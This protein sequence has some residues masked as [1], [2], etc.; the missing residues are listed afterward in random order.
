MK[1]F[2]DKTKMISLKDAYLHSYGVEK[3]RMKRLYDSLGD[4]L[5][6]KEF[7]DGFLA[8]YSYRDSRREDLPL[9]TDSLKTLYG[10]SLAY[11]ELTSTSIKMIM[12]E[13][14][15]D[16]FDTLQPLQVFD[17]KSLEEKEKA[18]PEF[19]EFIC[20]AADQSD[21]EFQKEAEKAL[22]L[23]PMYGEEFA[24]YISKLILLYHKKFDDIYYQ[25]PTATVIRR[26][27]DYFYGIA[28][29]EIFGASGYPYSF[30]MCKHMI[31]LG[32]ISAYEDRDLT[33]SSSLKGI[34]KARITPKEFLDSI[35]FKRDQMKIREK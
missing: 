21:Q 11:P 26:D 14:V 2:T 30:Y 24:K 13:F 34:V 27:A 29:Q 22:S 5:V 25:I 16:V 1:Y 12:G 3:P 8:Y 20:K 19:M 31:L 15:P 7:V 23:T 28:R 10:I 32:D 17:G 33:Y 35:Q 6:S 18:F 9:A 4:V